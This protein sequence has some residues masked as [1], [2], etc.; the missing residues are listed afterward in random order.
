MKLKHI[1]G[2]LPKRIPIFHPNWDRVDMYDADKVD[3]AEVEIDEKRIKEILKEAHS[4]P[5]ITMLAKKIANQCPI[6]RKG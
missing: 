5:W 3:H 6:R 4:E 2:L 1:K